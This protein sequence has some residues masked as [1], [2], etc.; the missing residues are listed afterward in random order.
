MFLLT[1]KYNKKSKD[2]CLKTK[3]FLGVY[4]AQQT[5]DN[6]QQTLSKNERRVNVF[7]FCMI[8]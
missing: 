1:R 5:M 2:K 4:L 6:S 3:V 7:S 8:H